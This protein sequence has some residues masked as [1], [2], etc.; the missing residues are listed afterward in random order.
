MEISSTAFGPNEVIP[1]EFTCDGTDRSPPL[2]WTDAPEGTRSFVLVVD[3]P[4][5]PS[6]T[7]RHWG[8]YDLAADRRQLE[9]GVGNRQTTDMR[10]AR[11]DFGN[12]G[13]GGPCPP[14]GH[15]PH[16]YRFQLLALNVAKLEAGAKPTIAQVLERAETHLLGSSVLTGTYERR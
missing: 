15:G 4:D 7:F 12:V 3:D 13:Y 2:Q 5:A 9:A 14:R 6:G 1:V 16:R 10:Q 8:V 11:N